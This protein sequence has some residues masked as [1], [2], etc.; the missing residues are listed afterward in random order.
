MGVAAG[1]ILLPLDA[2]RM[3]SLF[4]GGEVNKDI[5]IAAREEDIIDRHFF[6]L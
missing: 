6:Y 3:E 4:L 5:K 1:A 2:L